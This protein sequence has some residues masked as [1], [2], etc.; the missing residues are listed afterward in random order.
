VQ[1]VSLV[2]RG[3]DSFGEAFRAIAKARSQALLMRLPG[4]GFYAHFKSIAQLAAKNRLP[5]ISPS[6]DWVEAGGLMMYGAETNNRYRRAAIYIDKILKGAKPADLPVEAPIKF[7]LKINL[8]TANAIG[9]TIPPNM[10]ARA[11]RVIR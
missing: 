5:S 1:L 2:A 7:E 11:D 4:N 6:V 9:L 10:L 8:K 3:P